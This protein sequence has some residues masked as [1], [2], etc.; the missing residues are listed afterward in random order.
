F[1]DLPLGAYHVREVRQLGYVRTLPAGPGFVYD[2]AVTAS[3]QVLA[4]RD[5]GNQAKA[6]P[7]APTALAIDP[8][9]GASASDGVT[10]TGAVTFSGSLGEAGLLVHVYDVTA[11]TDLGDAAV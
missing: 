9:A 3:G 5:F 11:G 6:P 7:A 10:N 4:D 8:D 1:T 2:V